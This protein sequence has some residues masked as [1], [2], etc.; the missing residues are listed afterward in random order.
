MAKLTKEQ[1]KKHAEACRV[2]QKEKLSLEER[3]FVLENWREDASHINSVA[4]AF[5]TPP[6]LAR[7]FAIEVNGRRV[8]D[9]CAGIGS[10]A[11]AVWH[12]HQLD[13]SSLNHI[14]CVEINPDYVAVGKKILPEATWIVADVFD[15]TKDIG[16]FDCA[17]SNPPFGA[18]KKS[19]RSPRFF[20]SVLTL[21]TMVFSS[22]RKHLP[23][24][25]TVVSRDID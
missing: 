8:V 1:A 9:L 15:L 22:C 25:N 5:F 2:L 4:G 13:R 7:D 19:G 17:I 3:Y 23:H 24:S 6:G 20:G 11:F 18:A 16:H 14:T 12:R 21:P 10:L